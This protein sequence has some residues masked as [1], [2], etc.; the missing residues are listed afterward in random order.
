M[1]TIRT[2]A[3]VLRRTNYGEADRVVQ[4]LTPSEGK[5]SVMARGVRREKSKLAG[6]IELFARCDVTVA[7]GRG[8]L[9]ILTGS[10]LEIFYSHIMSDYDRLQFGY[11]AIKQ[12]SKAAD[13]MDEP[14]FFDLLDQCFASLND[15]N[16]L[17]EITKA[18][19]WLQLAILLGVGLNLSTDAEGMKLVEDATYNFSEH[20]HAF[21][22]HE[23]GNFTSDHIKVLRVLSAQSPKVAAQVQ[24]V[25]RLITDCLWVAE[26]AVAH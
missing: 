3:I 8:E 4:F 20:D 14:A 2:K 7:T 23:G 22:F 26:R 13:N 5:L 17:L 15:V 19:F 24:G 12:L 10:R 6:G 25:G 18:W 1:R 16:V 11:D 9:G 21:V